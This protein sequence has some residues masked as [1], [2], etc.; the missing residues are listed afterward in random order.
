[1][2]TSH[3]EDGTFAAPDVSAELEAA[4]REFQAVHA[5]VERYKDAREAVKDGL[6]TEAE[7]ERLIEGSQV[8]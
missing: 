1:M 2:T 8:V 7:A 3:V 4:W 5:Y 6:L